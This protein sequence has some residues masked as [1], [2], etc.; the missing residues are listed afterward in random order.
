MKFRVRLTFVLL[1]ITGML[2]C[3]ENWHSLIKAC[4]DNRLIDKEF[5]KANQG[6]QPNEAGEIP[7]LYLVSAMINKIGSVENDY[8]AFFPGNYQLATKQPSSAGSTQHPPDFYL[9]HLDDTRKFVQAIRKAGVIG[10]ASE[11]KLLKE[12]EAKRLLHPYYA[13][14]SAALCVIHETYHQQESLLA[15]LD[16]FA[17]YLEEEQAD[18]LRKS[19]M[20]ERANPYAILARLEHYKPV[21]LHKIET[22]TDLLK[23]IKKNTLFANR[24]VIADEERFDVVVDTLTTCSGSEIVSQKLVFKCNYE[25]HFISFECHADL[26]GPTP[27]IKTMELYRS[28]TFL[29]MLSQLCIDQNFVPNPRVVF[30]DASQITTECLYQYGIDDLSAQLPNLLPFHV[31]TKGWW[32]VPFE[33][34]QALEAMEWRLS[35]GLNFPIFSSP[36]Y[37]EEKLFKSRKKWAIYDVIEASGALNNR[38]TAYINKFKR[39]FSTGLFN[40]TLGILHHFNLTATPPLSECLMGFP[41]IY[42]ETPTKPSGIH[43]FMRCISY[44][45]FPLPTVRNEMSEKGKLLKM[46]LSFPGDEKDYVFPVG[47]GNF[48]QEYISLTAKT[49]RKAAKTKRQFFYLPN[50]SEAGMPYLLYLSP[51]EA[52]RLQEGLNYLIRPF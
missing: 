33:Q 13:A 23:F 46:H 50:L 17:D 49:W 3:Q 51:D 24:T 12:V 30:L 27:S 37:T 34:Y 41:E 44:N 43:Q 47:N 25:K 15:I 20:I 29:E 9:Q 6:K 35:N 38:Q 18:S 48:C 32:A 11:K 42:V 26:S 40:D 21:T 36:G 28:M 45:E 14:C 22:A 8:T 16:F 52:Y 4:H 31:T 39:E 5:Y 7:K 10:E 2:F 19:I 1:F